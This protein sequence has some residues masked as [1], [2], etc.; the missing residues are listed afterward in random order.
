VSKVHDQQPTTGDIIMEDE[1]YIHEVLRV[2]SFWEPGNHELHEIGCLDDAPDMARAISSKTAYCK[3]G[4]Y[5]TADSEA[6][7][8]SWHA[9][10]QEE[11][12]R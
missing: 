11:R 12:Q 3:C 8:R 1:V 10:H 2:G 5:Y 7:R 6:A 9:A 4:A